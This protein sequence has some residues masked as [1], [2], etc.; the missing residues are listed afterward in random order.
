MLNKKTILLV[1][2]IMLAA[3]LSV[4]ALAETPAETPADVAAADAAKAAV[5]EA[6]AAA[7]A[8]QAESAALNEALEAW[9]KAKTESRKL[10][11][12]TSLK[13]ELDSFVA[14]GSLTQEQADLILK[15][16]AEQLTLQPQNVTGFGRGSRGGRGGKG[17]GRGMNGGMDSG[18]DNNARNSDFG[19]G[20]RHGRFDNFAPSQ[21]LNQTQAPAAPD[22][23]STDDI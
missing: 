11:I 3:C 18:M 15:Y 17:F 21:P 22:T 4:A 20:G 5:T 6:Q 10:S 13:E 8:A 14:D 16:Y 19:F 9:N 2:A 12:L 23:Q 1:L 7:E